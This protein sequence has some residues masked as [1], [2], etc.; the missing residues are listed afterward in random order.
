MSPNDGY[1]KQIQTAGAKY[2]V[3][4]NA[5]VAI[6]SQEGLG[7]GVG[8]NGTS[9]GPF[10][11]HEGGALPAGKDQ[12]WAESPAGIDYAV[13]QIKNVVGNK[14]GADAIKAIATGFEKSTDPQGEAARALALYEGGAVNL[15]SAG[16]GLT[17]QTS[18]SDSGSGSGSSSKNNLPNGNAVVMPSNG[19]GLTASAVKYV[20]PK[21]A[22][23]TAGSSKNGNPFV[24]SISA[25]KGVK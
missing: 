9:F 17:S 21:L 25:A 2:G 10:Q 24:H 16:S 15:G 1:L 18:G 11:M 8:D 7:G 19:T 3:D 12:A 13:Q 20:A 6:A 14:T 23:A 22:V 4:I 5:L